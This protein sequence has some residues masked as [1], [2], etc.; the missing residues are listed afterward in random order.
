MGRRERVGC[1]G[2]RDRKYLEG[3]GGSGHGEQGKRGRAA[4]K[5]GM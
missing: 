1:F 2:F 5:V 3:G 4:G